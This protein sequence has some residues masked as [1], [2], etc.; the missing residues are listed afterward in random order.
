MKKF[1]FIAGAR[2]NF[3]K[4]APLIRACLNHA[5]PIQPLLVHT[6]QHYDANMSGVFFEE[7]GI[8]EP[9]FHLNV[10]GGSHAVQTARIMEAFEPVLLEAAPDMV[11]V[12]GDVNSTLACTLVAKKLDFP[13]AHVEAGLRSGDRT[14]PE[15]IN[16]LMVDVVADLLLVSE[17]SGMDN[18]A[19]EG[20]D[21]SRVKFIGNVMVD[22]L[23]Y[24]RQKLVEVG[25]TSSVVEGFG[26]GGR[27]FAVM[28]LHRPATVDD[29]SVLT[30][31]VD[32]LKTIAAE[33]PIIFPV[34]P[35]TRKNLES[36]GLDLGP[37]ITLVEP[38]GY[39]EFLALWSNAAMVLTDSGGLQ[40]ETTAL[41][42]PCVTIRDN[43]ERPV[44]VDQGSNRLAGRTS[45]GIL[46]AYRAQRAAGL[47]SCRV[48]GW[49][50]R[51][52]E[53]AVDA[54]V[55]FSASFGPAAH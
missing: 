23:F 21:A 2:P 36:F 24:Q 18:L 49:D 13:V 48:D 50:G 25:T 55:A 8:P 19:A 39:S 27:E 38:L 29:A 44:T 33:L 47:Q 53:R 40:E 32:A 42:I 26:V 45:E 20:V 31:V 5:E 41:G 52:A 9:D 28:T 3:M 6:G 37:N 11:V 7:L 12:V 35:R 16:R 1:L 43:T 4:I 54:F 14:M 17:P 30:G 22:T 15:E 10:G 34:H 51:A 46:E